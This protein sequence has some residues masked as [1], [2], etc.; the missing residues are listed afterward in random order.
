MILATFIVATVAL[1]VSVIVAIYTR[2]SVNEAVKDI[3]LRLRP[4]IFITS[5]TLARIED[6][7]GNLIAVV[8]SVTGLA[9]VPPGTPDDSAAIY[10]LPISNYGTSPGSSVGIFA[11]YSFAQSEVR[12]ILNAK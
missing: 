12:T 9:D 11:K 2:T 4:W 8:D 1:A 10:S 7:S 5:P 6:P 3:R